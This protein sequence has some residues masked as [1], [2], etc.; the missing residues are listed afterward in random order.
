MSGYGFSFFGLKPREKE[1]NKKKRDENTITLNQAKALNVFPEQMDV[2]M[3]EKDPVTGRYD[4][5]GRRKTRGRTSRKL[6][7]KKSKKSR[8][9][10]R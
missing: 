8:K 10:R 9:H 3:K 6:R 5:G 1:E 2:E 4:K 7:T